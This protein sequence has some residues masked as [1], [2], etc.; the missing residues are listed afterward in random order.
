MI[1]NII[2][3]ENCDSVTLILRYKFLDKRPWPKTLCSR[4][5][6][7]IRIYVGMLSEWCPSE[8]QYPENKVRSVAPANLP[9]TH[10]HGEGLAT[11]GL[12]VGED[13]PVVSLDH[14]FHQVVSDVV[15]NLTCVRPCSVCPVEGERLL[16]IALLSRLKN[17]LLRSIINII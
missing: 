11:S 14:A 1:E 9:M 3:T 7:T 2:Q 6:T 8:I 17:S 16:H 13:C 4:Q 12:S 10:L 5:R 15:V